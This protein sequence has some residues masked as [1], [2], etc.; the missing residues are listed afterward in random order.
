M[1]LMIVRR[2]FCLV[3]HVLHKCKASEAWTGSE[4]VLGRRELGGVRLFGYPTK[5]LLVPT[6]LITMIAGQIAS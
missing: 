5:W 4:I 2:E 1:I 6:V 3:F